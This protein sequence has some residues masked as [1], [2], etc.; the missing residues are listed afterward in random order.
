MKEGRKWIFYWHYIILNHLKLYHC[1]LKLYDIIS[2]HIISS[3]YHI[4]SFHIRIY[5]LISKYITWF[6]IKY[7]I[8][9]WYHITS[10]HIKI[11]HML[12]YQN[13]SHVIISKYMISSWYHIIS[14]HLISKYITWFYIKIYH[15]ILISYQNI[16]SHLDIISKYIIS[17]WFQ[18]TLLLSLTWINFTFQKCLFHIL[19]SRMTAYIHLIVCRFEEKDCKSSG[20][21]NY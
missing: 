10:S 9:S 16:S 2:N 11:Y 7:I 6:H 21:A 19:Y 15:L 5:H 1:D 13:I 20:H 8:S 18:V 3:W 12:S 14:H 4:K 17:S